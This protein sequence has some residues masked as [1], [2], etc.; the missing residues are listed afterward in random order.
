MRSP[1]SWFERLSVWV[2]LPLLLCYGALWLALPRWVARELTEAFDGRLSIGRSTLQ[3]PFTLALSHVHVATDS[4]STGLRCERITLRPR[5]W[6]WPRRTLWLDAVEVEQPSFHF[7]RTK[8][9]TVVWPHGEWAALAPGASRSSEPAWQVMV[10]TVRVLNGSVVFVDQQPAVPFR[11]AVTGLS[12][13]GGPF[14]WPFQSAQRSFAVQAQVGGSNRLAAT[15]SCSGWVDLHD[16]GL[17]VSCRLAP[18]PLAALEPY[19]ED[20]GPLQ[21]RVYDAALKATAHLVSKSNQLDGRLQLEIGHLSEADLSVFGRTVAD[22]KQLAGE[23]PPVLSGEVQ[24]AGPLD[25]LDQW[26]LTLI[27]GNEIVRDLIKPLLD[28]RIGTIPVRLGGQA[29]PV[30]STPATEEAM[31]SVS[32]G[33]QQVEEALEILAP[34]QPSEPSPSSAEVPPQESSSVPSAPE[35]PSASEVPTTESATTE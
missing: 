9:G 22:V 33:S 31:S 6:S 5:W 28:R 1:L 23:S 35:I 10:R 7:A 20:N 11:G 15:V 19:Y 18:L 32:A 8:E 4:P 13:I 3:F 12:L 2:G 17:D 21:V 29:I 27:P 34:S 24:I 30:G 26:E 14:E 16:R 25:R